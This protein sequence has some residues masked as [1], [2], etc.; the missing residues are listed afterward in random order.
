MPSS[1]GIRNT[2]TIHEA[3][4]TVR[5][6]RA[7]N[8]RR[9]A[10]GEASSRRRSSARKKV[11]SEVTTPLKARNARKLTNSHDR[12]SRRRKSPNSS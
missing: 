4:T 8:S 7:R 11:E 10:T 9:A 2:T 6:N 3:W 5:V 12:P 1:T